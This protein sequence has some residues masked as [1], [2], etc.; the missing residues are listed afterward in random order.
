MTHTN[1]TN[2]D[3]TTDEDDNGNRASVADLCKKFDDKPLG[4]TKNGTTNNLSTCKTPK[5]KT[6]KVI[7]NGEISSSANTK[8]T[9]VKKNNISANK[10]SSNS[11]AATNFTSKKSDNLSSTKCLSNIDVLQSKLEVIN[12]GDI[13]ENGTDVNREDVST[14]SAGED[15][16]TGTQKNNSRVNNFA[17]YISTKDFEKA[18]DTVNGTN[19]TETAKNDM[20]NKDNRYLGKYLAQNVSSH[21]F[22]V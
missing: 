10:K 8:F 2:T 15:N 16:D 6:S 17:S 12:K 1:S 21:Y 5:L 14:N 9:N 19:S 13:V 11:I 18:D 3:N 4:K 20:D 22:I 7:E